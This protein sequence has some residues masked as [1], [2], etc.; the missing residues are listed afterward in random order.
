MQLHRTPTDPT[1]YKLKKQEHPYDTVGKKMLRETSNKLEKILIFLQIK[2]FCE[3][4]RK[5][6]E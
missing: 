6:D 2:S 5:I 3:S 4:I 1:V